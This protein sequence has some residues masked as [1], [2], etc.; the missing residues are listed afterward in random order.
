M[1]TQSITA[2]IDEINA[3]LTD[4]KSERDAMVSAVAGRT[5]GGV[6]LEE[7]GRYATREEIARSRV[8]LPRIRRLTV[9]RADLLR[10]LDL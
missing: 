2:R 7:G 4:L 1:N 8:L 6:P 5:T 3:Q 9:E 10:L